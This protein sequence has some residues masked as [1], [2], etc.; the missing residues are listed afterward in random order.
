MDCKHA[1]FWVFAHV[2]FY[3]YPNGR[4]SGRLRLA[5]SDRVRYLCGMTHS[6]NFLKALVISVALLGC[7]DRTSGN[8]TD[9][10]VTDT[11][12]STSDS[13]SDSGT[14]LGT[15]TDMS[16]PVDSGNDLGTVDAG[17]D[18]GVVDA[19]VDSGRDA[20]TT[21]DGGA[22]LPS[23]SD[24]GLYAGVGCGRT[25]VSCPSD[26]ECFGITGIVAGPP[27]CEIPCSDSCECP[28]DF[29]C[30][31][32]GDKTGIH[33]FCR[34][35][36]PACAASPSGSSVGLTCTPEGTECPDGYECSAF[37]GDGISYTCEIKCRADCECPGGYTCDVRT[38]AESS[39]RYC[40]SEAI[41]GGS[42]S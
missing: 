11:G 42:S 13:G 1:F 27:A 24:D 40:H 36:D 25:G 22:C 5:H 15:P 19:A 9:S 39:R 14:D 34:L 12:M 28:S 2:G 4:Q 23:V 38:D 31:E 21:T 30:Q 41:T 7:S 6:S 37:S 33:H 8:E 16:S 32:I 29:V 10:G 18:L 26:Y 20:G 3:F 17:S 35:P